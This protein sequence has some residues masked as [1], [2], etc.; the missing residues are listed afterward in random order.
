MV[1]QQAE[2]VLFGEDD[3]GTPV[4]F[5]Y[6]YRRDW[7]DVIQPDE[8]GEAG[9]GFLP[10]VVPVSA[11]EVV[12]TLFKLPDSVRVKVVVEFG[13]FDGCGGE[14]RAGALFQENDVVRIDSVDERAFCFCEA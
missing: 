6:F 1:F 13:F 10:P 4:F 8:S 11:D 5:V 12:V 14:D 3:P 9:A 7:F 2:V